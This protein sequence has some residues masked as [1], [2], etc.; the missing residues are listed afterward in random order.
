M[1]AILLVRVSTKTQDFDEQEREIYE[2]AIKDG[3]SPDNIIPVCE[4]ESGIKLSEEERAGLIKMKDLIE[5]DSSINCVYCWEVSRIAR[6]KKINFSVL[7]YLI[8]HKIQLV[9]KNPSIRLF[10]DNGNI[11]EGAEMIFTLFSQMAESE[12]RTKLARWKR[13]KDANRKQSIY[14]GGWLLY[15]YKIDEVTKKIIPSEDAEIVKMIFDMYLTG[16]YSYGSLAKEL[17][18]TG[19][20]NYTL[21][22]ARKMVSLTLNNTAYAGEPSSISSNSKLSTEG[23]VYPAIVTLD[24]IEK[25]KEIAKKNICKPKKQYNNYYFAKGLLRC[26]YC[27][28]IMVAK[29]NNNTYHCQSCEKGFYV[30]INLIDSILWYISTVLYASKLMHVDNEDRKQYQQQLSICDSKITTSESNIKD[31]EDRI[32]KIE[33]KAYVEGTLSITKAESFIKE[34]NQKIDNEKWNINKWMNDR[35]TIQ[36]MLIEADN[37]SKGINL[38][39]IAFIKDDETRYNIIHEVL[40]CA[41]IDKLDVMKYSISIYPRLWNYPLKFI[42]NTRTNKVFTDI[43]E[44]LDRYYK[45][46]Q[47]TEIDGVKTLPVSEE[48]DCYEQR[49]KPAKNKNKSREYNVRY[50]QEHKEENARRQREY[51]TRQKALKTT[52]PAN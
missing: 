10:K 1:K 29:K 6:R 13:T 45:N 28:S 32:E 9:I 5:S 46:I 24:M 12:M 19:R 16:N 47:Y 20:L 11:D 17:V 37:K 27:G 22:T 40:D 26:P 49:F 44:D 38:D 3:Y 43:T 15:G 30:Q 4:K 52:E 8:N 23:N 41:F 50:G 36:Q 2:M 25:C 14:T 35:A 18:Q 33:Y 42:L 51:R 48:I 34:L 39:Q 31:I 7:D 21:V